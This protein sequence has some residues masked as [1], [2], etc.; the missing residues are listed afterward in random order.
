MN[1]QTFKDWLDCCIS[2]GKDK[3]GLD[4]DDILFIL[5]DKVKEIMLEKKLKGGKNDQEER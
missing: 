4:N 3:L 5:M 1:I 2:D